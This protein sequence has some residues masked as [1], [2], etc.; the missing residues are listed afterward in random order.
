MTAEMMCQNFID[1]MDTAFDKWT[2][3]NR[4]EIVKV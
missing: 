4:Y 3:R 2:P 1:K